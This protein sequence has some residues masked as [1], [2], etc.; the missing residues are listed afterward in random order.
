M[1]VQFPSQPQFSYIRQLQATK[2]DFQVLAAC[3]NMFN[4]PDSWPSGFGGGMLHT[5]ETVARSFE[6]KTLEAHFVAVSPENPTQFIGACFCSRAT[7]RPNTWY[8]ALL[9][10]DPAFQ[11]QGFGK[12]LLL[13]ALQFALE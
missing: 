8:V 12:A 7:I 9:G 11:G 4:D 13:K 10:V 6:G 1:E 2:E 5:A 3:Y